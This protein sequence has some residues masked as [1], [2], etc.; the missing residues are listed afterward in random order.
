LIGGINQGSYS[1]TPT[2]ASN[3]QQRECSDQQYFLPIMLLEH[4]Q[5]GYL[6]FCDAMP[7]NHHAV[8]IDIPTQCVCPTE[9]EAIAH[10]LAHHLQCKDPCIV[11][12]YNPLLWEQ[13]HKNRIAA[14]AQA[15]ILETTSRLSQ[16]SKLSMKRLAMLLQ[17][18]SVM[19][20]RTV[21]KSMWVQC[22]GAHKSHAQ[23]TANWSWLNGCAIGSSVL[24]QRAKKGSIQQHP[25]NFNLDQQTIQENIHSAYKKFH[26]LEVDTN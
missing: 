22:H 7:S 11:Q 20:K 18:I 23:L 5:T 26:K 10:P 14:Q 2:T 4:C 21:G 25:E 19:Q 17:S 13:L 8:W 9:P 15:L 24:H 3:S 6:A 12:K 16:T 1:A